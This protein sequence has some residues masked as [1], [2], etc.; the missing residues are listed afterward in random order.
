MPVLSRFH[1]RETQP[2]RAACAYP[3]S[4]FAE[5]LFNYHK[6]A[7]TVSTFFALDKR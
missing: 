4:T 1:G 5:D 3:T 2:E 7:G 6:D